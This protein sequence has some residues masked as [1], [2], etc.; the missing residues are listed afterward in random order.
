VHVEIIGDA[1]G[2]QLAILV[3]QANSFP[4]GHNFITS[5]ETDLQFGIF[6]HP[7]GHKI[8]RHRHPPYRREL[9]S[10]S[11]VV[12]IH[13]G[14]LTAFIFDSKE[15]L[16]FEGQLVE[17]DIIILFSGGH[18]FEILEDA[19]ILEV[20]QGPYAGDEDKELF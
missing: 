2:K 5:P 20:K 6:N 15:E 10:T 4:P 8:A 19:T 7:A 11:E 14:K 13:S 12:I 16:V 1:K 18:G 9:T 3:R 17:G